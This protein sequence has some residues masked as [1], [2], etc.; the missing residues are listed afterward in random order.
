MYSNTCQVKDWANHKQIC[1]AIYEFS[2][3]FEKAEPGRGDGEDSRVF[4]S[5]LTPQGQE[6]L[7]KLVGRKC[8]IK[9]R[10]NGVK[11]PVLFDT[12]AQVSIVSS[13][14][15][16]EHFPQS[17]TQDI[18]DLFDQNVELELT[19]ANGSK[20]P[21]N[22]WVKMDFQLLNSNGDPL[23]VP[24]LV[25][26]FELDQPIIGYNVIEELIKN[27][28]Q[29]SNEANLISLLSASFFQIPQSKLN[30][31]VNFIGSKT[32]S[33]YS[34]VKTSKKDIIVPKGARGKNVLSQSAHLFTAHLPIK[35]RT[36]Q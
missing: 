3:K 24:M 36:R 12:G 18:K 20:L 10:M 29:V 22:G 14:Q 30:A 21:Y 5:H 8:L 23:E 4:V 16:K 35:T 28:E 34:T 15:L 6:K 19:T 32:I 31:F 11:L 1:L 13:K 25:T 26:E 2:G 9:C 17:E 7:S 27:Q 33:T